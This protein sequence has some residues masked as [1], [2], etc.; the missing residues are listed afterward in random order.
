[1][2]KTLLVLVFLAILTISIVPVVRAGATEDAACREAVQDALDPQAQGTLS[3][4]DILLCKG[5]PKELL[6]LLQSTAQ[7][8]SACFIDGWFSD[9]WNPELENALAHICSAAK[10]CSCDFALPVYNESY[11]SRQI[12]NNPQLNTF[13]LK[14]GEGV[15]LTVLQIIEDNFGQPRLASNWLGGTP[16]G[17]SQ[18][19]YELYCE[20]PLTPSLEI[21]SQQITAIDTILRGTDFTQR[22]KGKSVSLTNFVPARLSSESGV[23]GY[24][25]ITRAQKVGT[26][27]PCQDLLSALGV[28]PQEQDGKAAAGD[29]QGKDDKVSL[30]VPEFSIVTIAAALA[31][32]ITALFV[33]RRR[34]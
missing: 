2:K 32:A 16:R 29:G 26:S 3:P 18:G 1:M 34:Q 12:S 24:G 15:S 20:P 21:P 28:E 4:E 31:L 8:K 11:T 19:S 30:G 9:E 6:K 33:V 27:E 25:I 10:S 13:H 7:V 14:R 23:S 17:Y 22:E 5:S